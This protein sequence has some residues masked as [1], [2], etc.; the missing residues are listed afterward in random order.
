MNSDLVD[1]QVMKETAVPLQKTLLKETK[2]VE[3]ENTTTDSEAGAK[4]CW[5][6]ENISTTFPQRPKRQLWCKI[7]PNSDIR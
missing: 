1:F 3:F 6:M 2:G 4:P 5:R 7:H